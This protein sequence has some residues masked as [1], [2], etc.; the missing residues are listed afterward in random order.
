MRRNSNKNVI[1]K[2]IACRK[3]FKTYKSEINRGGGKYCSKNCAYENYTRKLPEKTKRTCKFCGKSF[4][5]YSSNQK[6]R[7]RQF[8]NITCYNSYRDSKVKIRCKACG[9]EFVAFK[10]ANRVFC[11][12][13]CSKIGLKRPRND[14]KRTGRICEKEFYVPKAWIKKG[15]GNYCSKECHNIGQTKRL[16]AFCLYCAKEF[17]FNECYSKRGG[18]KFCSIDCYNKN[19]EGKIQV[20]CDYCGKEFETYENRPHKYCSTECGYKDKTTRIVKQCE[21]CGSKFEISPS[22][23]KNGTGRYCS[24]ECAMKSKLPTN[25]EITGANILKELEIEFI[26]QYP[27]E[28]K[29]IVDVYIPLHNLIIEWDGDY[30]HNLA[31]TKR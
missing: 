19:R 29:Y 17:E 28:N 25:L 5:I 23:V 11:S 7:E 15:N 6:D 8:C 22:K 1:T 12:L 31:S 16:K 30:W 4:S 2:C 20:E 27:I 14:V 21:H 10:S 13:E 26:E 3:E 9:K 18:G 24:I